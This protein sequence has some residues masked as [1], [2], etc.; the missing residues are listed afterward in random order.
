M[1]RR[2]IYIRD[3]DEGVWDK[4]SALAGEDSMSQIII[5]GLKNYVSSREGHPMELLKVDLLD[6]N[7]HK[8]TKKFSG[9]WLIEEFESHDTDA[10]VFHPGSSRMTDIDCDRAEWWVAET[11]KGQI[12]VWVTQDGGGDEFVVFKDLDDAEVHGGIP[13]DV[14]SAAST[15]LGIERAELLDI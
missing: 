14:C 4:A 8:S 2:N 6:E 7:D 3:E 15:A 10:G 5:R 12:A 1:G 11:A 9:R 13:G